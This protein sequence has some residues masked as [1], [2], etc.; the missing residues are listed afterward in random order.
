MVIIDEILKECKWYEKIIVK[1][2]TKLIIKTYHIV[3]INIINK[4]L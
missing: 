2:F 4:V 3:R 1:L